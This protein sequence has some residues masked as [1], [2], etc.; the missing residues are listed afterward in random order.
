[1]QLIILLVVIERFL[2]ND[3]R[4]LEVDQSVQLVTGN[5]P[6]LGRFLKDGLRNLHNA[7]CLWLDGI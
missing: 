6:F 3:L 7:G 1:M 5:L 2:V 4:P